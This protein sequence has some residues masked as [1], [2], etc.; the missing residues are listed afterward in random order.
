AVP[1]APVGMRA[2]LAAQAA[3]ATIPIVFSVGEDPV[4]LGL[5]TSLGR[6]SRNATGINFFTQEVVAKRLRLLHDLVPKAVRIAVLVNPA[7]APATE[8][9]LREV[10][11]AAPTLGLQIQILNVTTIGEIDAAFA[12]LA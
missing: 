5:I 11:E 6:P 12:S 2:A 1:D 10:R 8:S 4:R 9:T 7:N 3:T